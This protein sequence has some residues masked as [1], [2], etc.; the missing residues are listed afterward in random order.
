MK[1]MHIGTCSSAI[2]QRYKTVVCNVLSVDGFLK[3]IVIHESKFA[4][5]PFR[6][7][8]LKKP[9]IFLVICN[10]LFVYIILQSIKMSYQMSLCQINLIMSGV[11]IPE[12]SLWAT[13]DVSPNRKR[14]SKIIRMN[15]LSHRH[16]RVALR[17]GNVITGRP[18]GR[19][20]TK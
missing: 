15:H 17:T 11:F 4:D 8:L 16:S 19:L 20:V 13:K 9:L 5:T 10:E 18:L 2:E 12:V 6:L 1:S 7:C 14:V 3:C